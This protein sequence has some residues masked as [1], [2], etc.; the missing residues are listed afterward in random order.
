MKN[1]GFLAP[2]FKSKIMKKKWLLLFKI[3]IGFFAKKNFIRF[4][5]KKIKKIHFLLK[6]IIR[7]LAQKFK[8]RLFSSKVIFNLLIFVFENAKLFTLSTSCIHSNLEDFGFC[9]QN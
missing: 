4:L 3:I 5:A 8:L 9:Q 1:T 2:K 7:F 6:K